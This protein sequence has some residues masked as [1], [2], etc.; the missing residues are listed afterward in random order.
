MILENLYVI[1]KLKYVPSLE[2]KEMIKIGAKF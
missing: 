2:K 1:A